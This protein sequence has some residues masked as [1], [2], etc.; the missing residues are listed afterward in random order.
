MSRESAPPLESDLKE[1]IRFPF[2]EADRDSIQDQ[3]TRVVGSVPFN[4]S[5]RCP[6]LLSHVVEHTLEGDT[7]GL[8][9]RP[10]GIE[11]FRRDPNYDSNSDPV[12]RMAA[13]EVRKKLA[14]YYYD[15]SHRREIRIELPPG[16]YVPE[17]YRPERNEELASTSGQTFQE[18]QIIEPV[19]VA[20]ALPIAD[21]ANKKLWHTWLPVCCLVLGLIVG[22]FADRM[23]GRAASVPTAAPLTTLDEFWRP[24]ISAPGSVWLSVGQAYAEKILL[25]PNGARNRFDSHY[26]LTSGA[27]KTYPT[28]NMADT[29]ALVGVAS[30]LQSRNKRYSVHG[31][32]DTA[33][34]DLA[35][36]PS[37]LIGSF[38]NDWTIRLCDQLR[39]HFEMNRDTGEQWIV[40]R[41]KPD[42][43][44]G[45]HSS[46]LSTP[47]T[48]DAY[49]IIS[50]VRDPSTGQMVVALAG[51]STD[52]TEAAGT[53]VS[54][55][56]Y[57]E[58]FA[59]H[60][61]TNWQTA[62]LQIL[63]AASIVDG[64]PG[65]PRVVSSYVW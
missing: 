62:N 60:A 3:L 65:R 12:V 19:V 53:F 50:R 25:E 54:D 34:S 29:T 20:A 24:L 64:S 22:A 7:D 1:S 48:R 23:H 9:E 16:S 27:Q 13:G 55:P 56:A 39:F 63:I 37:V 59:Q 30:V 6:A 15:P 49:A 33:F 2:T 18:Q 52:G 28:L 44:I 4:S 17:F 14:Q 26:E 51:V 21:A 10:L 40:D 38:N 31:E 5:K 41:Q 11:V 58:D 35:N 57:L 61:P 8:K 32:S 43:K 47:D 46:N 42:E 36:G 45:I